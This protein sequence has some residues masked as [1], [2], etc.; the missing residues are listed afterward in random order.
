MADTREDTQLH[1]YKCAM[2]LVMEEGGL[3]WKVFGTFLV[4]HTIFMAFL[5]KESMVSLD[6]KWRPGSFL[7]ALFGVIL[8][9]PWFVVY[10]RNS[11][12]YVFYIAQ[13][14][15]AEP[16]GWDLMK[17]S[18][19]SFSAGKPVTIE[20]KVYRICWLGRVLRARWSIPLL[21]L[22]FVVIYLVVLILSGPW[23]G[24]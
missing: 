20:G 15:R 7:A 2:A 17:G 18:G 5:L 1:R 11:A 24:C 9:F 13:A 23:W 12:Y 10:I 22:G 14:K 4:A 8:C 19:E 3:L 6:A 16:S 21:I